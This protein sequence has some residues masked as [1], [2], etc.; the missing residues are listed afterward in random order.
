MNKHPTVLTQNLNKYPGHHLFAD[1]QYYTMKHIFHAFIFC[2]IV[3]YLLSYSF[4]TF[5]LNYD[6]IGPNQSNRPVHINFIDQKNHHLLQLES[7][8]VMKLTAYIFFMLNI[9]FIACDVF[10]LVMSSCFLYYILDNL[11]MTQFIHTSIYI[12]ITYPQKVYY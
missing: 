8:S 7:V 9:F 10:L 4:K 6:C 5:F 2:N 12:V 11:L 3:G 1:L